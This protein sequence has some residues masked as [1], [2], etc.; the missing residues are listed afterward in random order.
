METIKGLLDAMKEKAGVESNN[1]IAAILGVRRQRVTDYYNGDRIPDNIVCKRIAEYLE[2][3]LPEIIATVGA[4]SEK[5]EE[6][7]EEWRAYFK[8]LGGYAAAIFLWF[9]AGLVVVGNFVTPTH[10]EAAP[11]QESRQDTICI[12]STRKSQWHSKE[13]QLFGAFKPLFHAFKSLFA[14]WV[15]QVKPV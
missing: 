5:D 11:L 10:A 14:P 13:P 15:L 9:V 12:M 3:P 8:R 1:G 6:R 4:D 2:R 7:R